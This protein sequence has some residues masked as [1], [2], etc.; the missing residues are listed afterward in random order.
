LKKLNPKK[1]KISKK[2]NFEEIG[3]LENWVLGKIKKSR[4]HY[5]ESMWV[6]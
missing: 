1:K 5:L 4:E 2:W 6:R 3:E